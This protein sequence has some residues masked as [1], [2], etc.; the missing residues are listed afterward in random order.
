MAC[1]GRIWC[2]DPAFAAELADISVDDLSALVSFEPDNPSTL[3]NAVSISDDLSNILGAI[4]PESDDPNLR[5]GLL[6]LG[7]EDA[8]NGCNSR[9]CYAHTAAFLL[10][11]RR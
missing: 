1:K 6:D 8:R 11:F 5:D 4:A 7:A 9:G 2:S 3:F 10:V